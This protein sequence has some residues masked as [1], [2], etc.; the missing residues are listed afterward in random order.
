MFHRLLLQYIYNFTNYTKKVT[1]LVSINIGANII[2]TYIG[3]NTLNC[4]NLQF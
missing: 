3:T 2:N 4:K 1:E